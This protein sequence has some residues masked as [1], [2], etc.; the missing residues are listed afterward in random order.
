MVV[1]QLLLWLVVN[2][3]LCISFSVS[4]TRRDVEKLYPAIVHYDGRVGWYYPVILYSS[5][6]LDVTYFPW[7]HQNCPLDFTSWTYDSTAIDFFNNSPRA[8]LSRYITDGE[9]ELF[10]VPVERSMIYFEDTDEYYPIVGYRIKIKRK[11]LYYLYNLIL[12]CALL[13][14]CGVLVFMLPPDSGEK[15][16]MSVTMLLSSSVFLLMIA[17]SMPV[18][19]DTI[20]L[21]GK[22]IS[23]WLHMSTSWIIRLRFLL[24]IFSREVLFGKSVHLS[25]LNHSDRGCSV[26]PSQQLTEH[27]APSGS[28]N[29]YPEV[30]SCSCVHERHNQENA[31]R[32]SEQ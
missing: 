27:A 1:S 9:W 31:W 23:C 22:C 6:S 32:R 13:T 28:K 19:S 16:S 25:S 17:E 15:V 7:D 18:Q 14:F 20:P 12:P 26:R 29:L 8:D 3:T 21:I 30:A 4:V 2:W 5:C 11:P 24:I 10:E